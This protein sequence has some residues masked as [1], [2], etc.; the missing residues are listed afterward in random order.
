M[1]YFKH[2]TLLLFLVTLIGISSLKA[3]GIPDSGP[4]P[5]AP[6]DLAIGLLASGAA[7]LGYKKK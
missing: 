2:V 7:L 1:K 3:Q 5:D 6:L 4:D